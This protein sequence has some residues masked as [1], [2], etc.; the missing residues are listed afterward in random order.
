V[1]S[2]FVFAHIVIVASA[3]VQKNAVMLQDVQKERQLEADSTGAIGVANPT[4]S[5]KKGIAKNGTIK[6]PKIP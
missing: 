2:R 5:A 3:I 1:G 4:A 6:R